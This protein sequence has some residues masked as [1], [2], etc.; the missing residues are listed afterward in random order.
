M[1]DK[2]ILTDLL[3]TEKELSALLNTFASEC[4]S[5]KLRTTFLN[6]L[7]ESHMSQTKLFDCMQKNGYYQV[8]NATKEQIKQV[9]NFHKKNL[10][11]NTYISNFLIRS[12]FFYY[13]S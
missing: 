9:K 2:E 6:I 13:F 1:E 10:Y 12:C 3:N 5:P 4:A 7:D 11:V 8:K